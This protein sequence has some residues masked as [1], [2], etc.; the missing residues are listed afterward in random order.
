MDT[1][2]KILCIMAAVSTTYTVGYWIF[3]IIK[4]KI[5]HDRLRT[6]NKSERITDPVL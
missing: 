1:P 3:N 4:W 2:S 6:K 5:K